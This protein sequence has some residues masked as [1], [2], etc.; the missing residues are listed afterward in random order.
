[1][2]VSNDEVF[3]VV[4]HQELTEKDIL[5]RDKAWNIIQDLIIQE[6]NIYKRDKRGTLIRQT[7]GNF[8]CSKQT[9]YKYL[10]R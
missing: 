9:I 8:G 10:K 3:P 5:K 2:K 6:P 7:R 4:N 1:M